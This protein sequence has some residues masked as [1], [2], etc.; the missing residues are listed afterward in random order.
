M[1]SIVRG[2]ARDLLDRSVLGFCEGLH[3]VCRVMGGAVDTLAKL[4]QFFNLS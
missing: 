1:H 2:L 3:S 4:L